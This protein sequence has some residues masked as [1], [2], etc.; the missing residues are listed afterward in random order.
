M[1]YLLDTNILAEPNKPQPNQKGLDRLLTYD[2]HM[3]QRS[4]I[5]FV[6]EAWHA[7]WCWENFLPY[8]ANRGYAAYAVSLRGH[9][10]SE[11]HS[12]F[13]NLYYN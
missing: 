12:I 4:P 2:E 13:G 1:R 8:F 7:A 5:F 10:T 3:T 9:G 11:G 6:H